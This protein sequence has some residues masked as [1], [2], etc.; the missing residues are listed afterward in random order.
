MKGAAMA[1]YCGKDCENCSVREAEPCP[2]CRHFAE[3]GA[4]EIASCCRE[5]GHENCQTCTQRTWCPTVRTAASMHQY[6]KEK[7]EAERARAQRTR[8]TAAIMVRWCVPLFW[9]I[10][11]L[12]AVGLLGDLFEHAVVLSM[13]LNGIYILL[14]LLE[15][16]CLLKMRSVS[17]RYGNAAL[18]ILFSS[19]FSGISMLLSGMEGSPILGILIGLPGSVL[20]YLAIYH[21]YNAHSDAV[22]DAD[23]EL[24]E[25]WEKLWKWTIYALV[26][27]FLAVPVSSLLGLIGLLLLLAAMIAAVV[28]G[29]LNLIYLHRMIEAFRWYL[30]RE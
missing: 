3:D 4:C 23:G 12:E 13:I 10:L 7:A 8:E 2:G 6:R 18:F 5:K 22:V 25:K 14:Y 9:I 16:F 24:A 17:D 30:D 11:L 26:G 19:A 21:T 15:A 29:V 27:M 20:S 28:C 1:N